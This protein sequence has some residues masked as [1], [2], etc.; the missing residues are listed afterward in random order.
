[1]RDFIDT[2]D[3]EVR[4]RQGYDDETVAR[5]R[6]DL[7]LF[8]G[9]RY[10][11][12]PVLLAVCDGETGALIGQYSTTEITPDGRSASLGWWLSAA[13]R[14]RGLGVESLVLALDYV[15]TDLGIPH[16]TMGCGH[17]NGRAKAQI[18]R[19]GARFTHEAPFAMPNGANITALWFEHVAS[20]S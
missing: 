9:F 6:R 11:G 20:G 17:D 14:G 12:H 1:M 4:R 13:G 5:W 2:I 3:D 7:L 8:M 15:H 19:A 16:L 18:L 10:Q